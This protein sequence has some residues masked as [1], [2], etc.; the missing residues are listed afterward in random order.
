MTLHWLLQLGHGPIQEGCIKKNDLKGKSY[1]GLLCGSCGGIGTAEPLTERMN[2]RTTPLLA[3]FL[4]VILLFM[5]CL[6]AFSK[7]E[8]FLELLAFA[9]AII[10][11][12]CGF[13]FS[14]ASKMQ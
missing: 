12:V 11:T 7:S 4:C 1:T 8:Y 13:Y 10:G 2:K 6:A 14:S 3:I 9:S 5:I